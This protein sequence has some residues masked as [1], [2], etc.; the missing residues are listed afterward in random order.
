M[1]MRAPPRLVAAPKQTGPRSAKRGQR[2][3]ELG[4]H[5]ASSARA[6]GP[7]AEPLAIQLIDSPLLPPPPPLL[8]PLVRA[9]QGASEAERG[10]QETLKSPAGPKPGLWP[11]LSLCIDPFPAGQLALWRLRE[12][13]E[14]A[15]AIAKTLSARDI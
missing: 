1:R 2:R 6:L 14:L 11:A 13:E 4:P 7:L 5:L 3:A 15:V 8:L 12:D 9:R 10:S